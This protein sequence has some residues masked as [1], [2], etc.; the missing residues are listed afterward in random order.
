MCIVMFFKELTSYVLT[1]SICLEFR[2]LRWFGQPTAATHPHLLKEGEVT[3]GISKTEYKSR[4][5]KLFELAKENF[6]NVSLVK[7]HILILPSATKLYMTNDIPYQFRQNSDFLYLTGFQEPDSLLVL[8]T[9]PDDSHD[10]HS[11]LFVPKKDPM[12]E[13]WDGPRSGVEG[14]RWLTGIEEVYNSEEL[15]R[16]CG[17]FCKRMGHFALWYNY[18]KPVHL[19]FDASVLRHFLKEKRHQFL[20]TTVHLCQKLRVIKSQAEIEL[21][22]KSCQVASN[23]FADVMKFSYPEVK[24][25]YLHAKMDFECRMRDAQFLAYPPVVAGGNRANTIHYISNDQ[26]IY[27]GELVLMDAGCEYF[28]YT[29]DISRTWP[30]S[31]KFNAAQQSLYEAVLFVQESCI[32]MCTTNHSLDEIYRKMLELIGHQLKKLGL[33][34]AKMKDVEMLKESTYRKQTHQC[35]QSSLEW[36]SGL[37]TMF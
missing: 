37:K 10:Y 8:H 30:V 1:K 9:S 28:G 6:K 7:N 25:S 31:G 3:L 33:I 21:M 17:D 32:A 23:A 29:S 24:E 4:R 18:M 5:T 20:E 35:A 11:V 2:A 26:I 16:F 13:L 14:A 34:S 27:G 12:K 22:S 15:E 19:E 36:V